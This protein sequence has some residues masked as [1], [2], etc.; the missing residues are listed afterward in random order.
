MRIMSAKR[1]LGLLLLLALARAE[2]LHFAEMSDL[3]GVTDAFKEGK[4]TLLVIRNTPDEQFERNF[5]ELQD[6]LRW[7][8][9]DALP[10]LRLAVSSCEL[11]P[12][13][14]EAEQL[15]PLRN[16]VHVLRK[17]GFK[18]AELARKLDLTPLLFRVLEV[19][20]RKDLNRLNLMDRKR[21]TVVF[22]FPRNDTVRADIDAA[23]G[24]V[25]VQSF[26]VVD[27]AIVTGAPV[28]LFELDTAENADKVFM[29]VDQ[30]L[31][32]VPTEDLSPKD[33]SDAVNWELNADVERLSMDTY[34]RIFMSPMINKLFLVKR[35]TDACPELVR[36][37]GEAALH[38]RYQD[39]YKNR[40]LFVEVDME[41]IAAGQYPTLNEILWQMVGEEFLKSRPC[42]VVLNS[43]RLNESVKHLLE[44]GETTADI[45]DLIERMHNLKLGNRF[46]KSELPG[47]ATVAGT[48]VLRVVG[49]NFR[50][51]VLDRETNDFLLICRENNVECG[52][53][54]EFLN[55]VARNVQGFDVRF[56]VLDA[57]RNEVPVLKIGALP[58][59]LFYRK[60]RK[61]TPE[62]MSKHFSYA[63][64]LE[65]TN[66]FLNKI[67]R[68]PVRLTTEDRAH[69]LRRL[70]EKYPEEFAG[71]RESFEHGVE[72]VEEPD[73]DL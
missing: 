39:L 69:L 11:V 72:F 42:T 50:E 45:L 73:T 54:T 13:F 4:A 6:T 47:E 55:V 17:S 31:V 14:C 24:Q 2:T 71:M 30:K 70:G 21:I 65:F 57:K 41:A 56:G 51:V 59:Y 10:H 37:F 29:T 46:Y 9:K 16:Y 32:R 23:V 3:K 62:V 19:R 60:G 35:T 53:L 28:D 8:F 7:D 12:S 26:D 22:N 44:K 48:S 58:A 15:D 68:P 1:T 67:D 33:I 40:V 20:T 52:A 18:H 27:F 25:A 63:A 34:Y 49:S 43:M 66:Q 38:N 5:A 36:E 64:L 61:S